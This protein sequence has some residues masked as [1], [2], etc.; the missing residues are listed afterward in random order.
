MLNIDFF[1]TNTKGKWI[2]QTNTHILKTKKQ[3]LYLDDLNIIINKTYY[4]S[5]ITKNSQ[6]N[7][8]IYINNISSHQLLIIYKANETIIKATCQKIDKYLIEVNYKN[9][10]NKY[11]YTEFIYLINKNLMFS[12]GILKDKHSYNYYAINITS[13]IKLNN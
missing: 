4:K 11:H 7:T 2:A 6:K 13:Y 5:S 9:I 3:Q 8:L 10:H 1:N 12:V